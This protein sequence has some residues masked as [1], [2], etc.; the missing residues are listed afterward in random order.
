MMTAADTAEQARPFVVAIVDGAERRSG[1]RMAAYDTAARSIGVTASWIRK[2][3]GRQPLTIEHH[4]FMNIALAYRTLCER[5]EAE[6]ERERQTLA[7][8]K[9][10]ADAALEGGAGLVAREARPPGRGEATG[11]KVAFTRGG[12]AA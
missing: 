9:G 1:S 4:E 3:I 6:A 8:L 2:L 12:C 10:R 7:A 11:P 5:I